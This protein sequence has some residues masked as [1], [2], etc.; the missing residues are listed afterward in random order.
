MGLRKGNLNKLEIEFHSHKKVVSPILEN[1]A[2]LFIVN[3]KRAKFQKNW[4]TFLRYLCRSLI[5][6]IIFIQEFPLNLVWVHFTTNY[7]IIFSTRKSFV[8]LS[9]LNFIKEFPCKLIGDL[10]QKFYKR[11][12]CN[13]DL[14]SFYKEFPWKFFLQGNPL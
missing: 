10:Q 12:P 7:R 4:R 13:F 14:G 1:S 11:I 9:L 5:T 3:F 8:K 6:T 2:R